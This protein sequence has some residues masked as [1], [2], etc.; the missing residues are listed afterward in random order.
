MVSWIYSEPISWKFG[1]A[2]RQPGKVGGS[3]AKW[4]DAS[5]RTDF[6]AIVSAMQIYTT[7]KKISTKTVYYEQSWSILKSAN[8]KFWDRKI[9]KIVIE[10]FIENPV[11]K[12]KI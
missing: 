6:D 5:N 2:E 3:L 11:A 7:L 12:K 10:M 1:L 4:S 9:S 8:Q